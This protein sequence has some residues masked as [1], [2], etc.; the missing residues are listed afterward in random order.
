MYTPIRHCYG[1]EDGTIF[2]ATVSPTEYIPL[3]PRV[4]AGS[5]PRAATRPAIVLPPAINHFLK[6]CG[7]AVC[8][9]YTYS[10][11]PD[12]SPEYVTNPSTKCCELRSGKFQMFL[13]YWNEGASCCSGDRTKANTQVQCLVLCVRYSR[14]EYGTVSRALAVI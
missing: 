2:N 6:G 7:H 3:Y 11:S 1:P 14:I 8:K 10:D 12:A 5:V 4:F 9:Y 13:W